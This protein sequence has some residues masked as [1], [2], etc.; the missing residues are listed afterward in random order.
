MFQKIFLEE[1]DLS[2]HNLENLVHFGSDNVGSQQKEVEDEQDA[3]HHDV[4]QLVPE[5]S[6]GE[7]ERRVGGELPVLASHGLALLPLLRGDVSLDQTHGHYHQQPTEQEANA[8]RE[9]SVND[10][11]LVDWLQ[12][13]CQGKVQG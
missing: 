1:E 5:M 13:L 12:T 4:L 7:E 10:G 6:V 8:T 2:C 3:D 11:P 9:H